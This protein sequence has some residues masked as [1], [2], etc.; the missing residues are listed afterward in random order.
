MDDAFPLIYRGVALFIAALWLVRLIGAVRQ[1]PDWEPPM[2]KGWPF[3]M[4]RSQWIGASI[5]GVAAGL[6]VFAFSY[7]LF[8]P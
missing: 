3:R 4:T 5:L 1:P 8:P 6:A 7:V 2:G